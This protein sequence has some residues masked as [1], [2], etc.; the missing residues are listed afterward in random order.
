[1]RLSVSGLVTT[2]ALITNLATSGRAADVSDAHKALYLQY[3]ASCHGPNGKG[4]GTLSRILWTKPADLTQIAKKN[5]GQFPF[6][7]VVEFI[8]GTNPVRAHGAPDMPVWGEIFRHEATTASEKEK[9]ARAQG[10]AMFITEY[11]RSIQD[12]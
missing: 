9:Q 4:D 6:Q 7:K 10:K 12:K 8:D 2:A 11:L 3:C 5:G 1:M